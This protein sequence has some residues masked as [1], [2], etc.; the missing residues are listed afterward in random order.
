MDQIAEAEAMCL[1]EATLKLNT[2]LA[3]AK[4]AGVTENQVMRMRLLLQA[5]IDPKEDW[6]TEGG[7]EEC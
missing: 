4:A 6:K 2:I 1:A 5:G 3:A 7:D